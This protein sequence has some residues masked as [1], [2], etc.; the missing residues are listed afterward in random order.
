MGQ[1]PYGMTYSL[2]ETALSLP[3]AGVGLGRIHGGGSDG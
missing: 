1:R 3:P 2:R